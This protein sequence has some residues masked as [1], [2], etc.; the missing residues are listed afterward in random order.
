MRFSFYN[1]LHNLTFM[2]TTKQKTEKKNDDLFVQKNMDLSS[3]G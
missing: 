1:Y 2:E 3:T